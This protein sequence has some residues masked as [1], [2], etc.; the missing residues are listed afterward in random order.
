MVIGTLWQLVWDGRGL[1]GLRS[2]WSGVIRGD[3]DSE[4]TDWG[5]WDNGDSV[6]TGQEGWSGVIKTLW[7][8]VRGDRG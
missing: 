4:A 2:N 5:S 6:V 3:W 8:L 1:S 7:Q